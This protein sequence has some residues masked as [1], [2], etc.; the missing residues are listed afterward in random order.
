MSA[1]LLVSQAAERTARPKYS[2]TETFFYRLDHFIENMMLQGIDTNYISFHEHC[3]RL[4]FMNSEVGINSKLGANMSQYG[5][6]TINLY[7]LPSIDL[8]FNIGYRAVDFGMS[9]DVR[10][11]YNKKFN[12]SFYGKAWGLEL[13]KNEISH[14]NGKFNS[15]TEGIIQE[16]GSDDISIKSTIVSAFFAFNFR[17]YSPIAG[18]RQGYRQRTSAGSAL[19]RLQ[20]MNLDIT[21]KAAALA[22]GLGGLQNMEVYQVALGAGYGYNYTPNQGKFLLHV[23]A[24][25]L[26]VFF[27]RTFYSAY[28]PVLVGEKLTSDILL[29]HKMQPSFPVYL[30]GTAR[31]C[32]A[33]EVNEWVSMSAAGTFNN[34]RFKAPA[35]EGELKINHWDW[36]AQV[37]IGVRFGAGKKRVSEVLRAYDEDQNKGKVFLPFL[38]KVP[39]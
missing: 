20:Y 18:I 8:G 24:M 34:M 9:W 11:A 21:P 37:L 5:N 2:K 22:T 32:L 15:D 30:T 10:R 29:S 33:W 26:L 7:S 39:H 17:K 12:F 28:F 19:L 25:P 14:L 38:D 6:A 35:T 16:V 31:L 1:C 13:T 36:S 3:W 27:N 4:S 23:S